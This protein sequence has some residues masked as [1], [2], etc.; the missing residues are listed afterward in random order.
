MVVLDDD[1]RSSI[2]AVMASEADAVDALKLNK[3]TIMGRY[4]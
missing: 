3:Q 4:V 2:I 1:V